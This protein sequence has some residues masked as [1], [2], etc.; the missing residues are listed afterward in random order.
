M[1]NYMDSMSAVA[2]RGNLKNKNIP[3][4][5]TSSAVWGVQDHNH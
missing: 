1:G 4:P 3:N 2:V 5:N